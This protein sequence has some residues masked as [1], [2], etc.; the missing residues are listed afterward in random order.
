MRPLSP[1][2][3]KNQPLLRC[4]PAPSGAYPLQTSSVVYLFCVPLSPSVRQG[5]IDDPTGDRL[6]AWLC[7][8]QAAW[9]AR[10]PDGAMPGHADPAE[11]WIVDPAFSDAEPERLLTGS[12]TRATREGD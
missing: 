9:A 7:A 3:S 2:G 4:W 8:L 1:T 11:G 12:I 6:D 5:L 10:H